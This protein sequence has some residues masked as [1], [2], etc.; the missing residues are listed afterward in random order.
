MGSKKHKKHKRERHEGEERPETR[1]T[2]SL[3]R[4]SPVVQVS[5]SSTGARD[6]FSSP[7]PRFLRRS[8]FPTVSLFVDRRLVSTESKQSITTMRMLNLMSKRFILTDEEA[9]IVE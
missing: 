3:D 8:I 2:F 6:Q 5:A 9:R 1:A 7:F 4:D